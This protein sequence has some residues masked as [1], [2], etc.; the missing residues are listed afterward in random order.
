MEGWKKD[1][2]NEIAEGRGGQVV[3]GSGN[4][5]SFAVSLGITNFQWYAILGRILR[6]IKSGQQRPSVTIARV[7]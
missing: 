4:G 6:E 2:R 3:S 1:T 7:L 5:T